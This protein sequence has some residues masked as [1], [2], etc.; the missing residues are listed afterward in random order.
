MLF[1]VP[2]NFQVLTSLVCGRTLFPATSSAPSGESPAGG[3]GPQPAPSSSIGKLATAPARP[4][5]PPAP[6]EVR[7]EAPEAEA[8]TP[9]EAARPVATA[10]EPAAAAV[11][12]ATVEAPSAEP[13]AEE[14]VATVEAAA[15]EI[16]EV[17][18]SDPQPAQE[19]VPKVV[20]R[21]H[22]LP[23]PVKVPFSRLMVKGQRVMEKI[24]E[25]LRQEWEELEAESLWL[26]YW[27]FCLGERIEA[28]TSRHAEERAQLEQERDD[29]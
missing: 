4:P 24:E 25:G 29:L 3:S 19:D 10:E 1:F 17:P 8:V 21:R 15:P 23:K 9:K 16:A 13:A 7:A 18:S 5:S 14:V 20:Y 22:L 2:F 27:E 11:P 12:D 26:S 6:A 28:V